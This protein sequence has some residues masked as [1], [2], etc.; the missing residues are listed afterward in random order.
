[1]P[2]IMAAINTRVVHRTNALLGKEYGER[3][4]YNEAMLTGKGNKGR[5][6]AKLMTL[7]LGAFIVAA[8]LKPTRY[9]LERFVLPAPGQG[10][11]E[12]EQETGYFDIRF[13]GY[14]AGKKTAIIETK[15]TGDKDPG[16]GFTGKMLGEAAVC[17]AKD[18]HNRGKK[19]WGKGGFWTPGALFGDVFMDRLRNNAGMTFEDLTKR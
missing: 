14:E 10:P 19:R 11:S 13:F 12:K 9:I 17:L 16:Y 1:M 7:G 2:F 5:R 15:V 4:L 18:Y 8:A 6:M 3:F